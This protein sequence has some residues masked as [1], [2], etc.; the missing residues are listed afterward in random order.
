MI[1]HL[2]IGRLRIN[3]T[4]E[5]TEA[6]QPD[7]YPVVIPTPMQVFVPDHADETTG[8]RVPTARKR[9]EGP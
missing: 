2:T 8:F 1:L 6:E 5:A 7:P 3:L 9:K 4:T